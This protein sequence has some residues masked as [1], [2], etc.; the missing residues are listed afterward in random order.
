MENIDEIEKLP[1]YTVF[2]A[3]YPVPQVF[4]Y[5]R[6]AKS[7]GINLTF[8]MHGCII[9]NEGYDE[10]GRLITDAYRKQKLFDKENEV[11]VTYYNEKFGKN[12]LELVREK[13]N[14]LYLENYHDEEED[15]LPF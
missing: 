4:Y 12:W 8:E 6:T 3:G 13:A 14:Q 2:V 5:P 9:R 1:L 11:A 10:N 7:L 15:G